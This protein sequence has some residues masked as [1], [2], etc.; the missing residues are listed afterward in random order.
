MKDKKSI[1]MI[2]GLNIVITFCMLTLSGVFSSP[3]Q[4][5]DT[6][7]AKYIRLSDGDNSISITPTLISIHDRNSVSN[8]SAETIF[9][10]SS[11]NK[12]KSMYL[13]KED[14]VILNDGSYRL[15]NKGNM[16]KYMINLLD[17]IKNQRKYKWLKIQLNKRRKNER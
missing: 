14:I 17:V 3:N 6:I 12:D 2:I 7:Y 11:E 8:L 5:H 16:S 1:I 4:F 15:S 13:N 10:G 9:L